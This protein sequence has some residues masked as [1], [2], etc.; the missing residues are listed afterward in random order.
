MSA[1]RSGPTQPAPRFEQT[2]SSQTGWS[3]IRGSRP[4]SRPSASSSSPSQSFVVRSRR[5][6]AE[7]IET[8]VSALPR[9]K[10]ENER[11]DAAARNVSGSDC[12]SHASFAGQNDG[13]R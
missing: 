13:C 4:A 1:A 9:R 7:A 8:L 2:A 12:A 11:K 6:V 3:T 10:S 5:P